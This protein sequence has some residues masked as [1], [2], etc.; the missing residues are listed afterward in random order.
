MRERVIL[1]IISIVILI[2][3]LPA[4]GQEK[5]P[6]PPQYRQEPAPITLH[7]VSKHVYE[8]RGGSGA[9]CAFIV[10]DNEVFVIDA[11]MSDQSAKDMIKAIEK[12]TDKPISHLLI[13]HSDGDHVNGI[14][15]FPKNIAIIAHDNT[16]KDIRNENE[17]GDLIIRLPDITFDSRM[18]LHSGGLEI[19]L[20]YFGPAHTD[21][22]IV[23]YI[24]DDNVAILGDLFVNIMDPVVHMRKNGT[25]EGLTKVLQDIIDLNVNAYLSGHAEPVKKAEIESIRNSL[26]G[27]R[28]KVKAMIK[29]GKSLDQVKG[30]FGVPLE[31]GFMQPLVEVIYLEITEGK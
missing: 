22:D 31:R 7:K 1:Y 10:G 13:T 25:S 19:N 28:E 30:A 26:I 12:T 4:L 16:D 21:G 17:K 18:N 20:L 29:E 6:Q 27:K 3:G 5:K 9:N 24:P 8:V 23:I 14:N 2:S 15:G 11:K